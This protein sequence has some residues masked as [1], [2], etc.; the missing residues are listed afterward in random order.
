MKTELMDEQDGSSSAVRGAQAETDEISQDAEERTGGFFSRVIGALSPSEEEN[1]DGASGADAS[2]AAAHGMMNLRRMRVDDVAV[3][4]AIGQSLTDHEEVDD[5]D[6]DTLGGLVF[7]LTGRVPTR[8]E[9]VVH[10]NGTEF[11]VI[12]ADPRRVKRLRVRT[13]TAG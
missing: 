3:P 8:G 7:M 9:V 10:P 5:E 6:I 2:P 11:E 1:T 13:G 12:D 4:K